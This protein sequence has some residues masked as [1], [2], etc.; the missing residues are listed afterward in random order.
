MLVRSSRALAKELKKRSVLDSPMITSSPASQGTEVLMGRGW[1]WPRNWTCAWFALSGWMNSDKFGACWKGRRERFQRLVRSFNFLYSK[2][3]FK[4]E[5]GQFRAHRLNSS[6]GT[7]S[8]WFGHICRS[9]HLPP[10]ALSSFPATEQHGQLVY[11]TDVFSTCLFLSVQTF[12]K[13]VFY[14]P[15]AWADWSAILYMQTCFI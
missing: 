14:Q 12:Q 2:N 8:S 3:K 1:F 11:L 9:P 10:E 5:H 13:F 4:V 15:K 7:P 6:T